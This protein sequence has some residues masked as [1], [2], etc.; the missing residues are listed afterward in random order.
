MEFLYLTY[1]I[2]IHSNYNQY[3]TYCLFVGGPGSGRGTQCELIQTKT[4]Y[5]HVSTGDVLRHEVMSGSQRGL[6]FYKL[7]SEGNAI[8]DDDIAELVRDVMMAKIIG[9]K[10]ISLD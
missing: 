1:S 9:S 2:V 3:W 6:K 5:T 8:P 10:V 7:M 4:G